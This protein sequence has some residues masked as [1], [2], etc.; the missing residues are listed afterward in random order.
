MNIKYKCYIL[1]SLK[2]TARATFIA[3]KLQISFCQDS[4]QN[5]GEQPLTCT[6]KIVFEFKCIHW[7]WLKQLLSLIPVRISLVHV[8][9]CITCLKCDIPWY[10]GFVVTSSYCIR[11]LFFYVCNIVLNVQV[12]WFSTFWYTFVFQHFGLKLA[13]FGLKFEVYGPILIRNRYWK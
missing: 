4:W 6:Y 3:L 7:F 12:Y 9:D 8:T 5:I 11:E 13:H 2:L 1:I 10:I